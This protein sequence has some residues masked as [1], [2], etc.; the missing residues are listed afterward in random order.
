MSPAALPAPAVCTASKRS[1]V[2]Y[3][4][5]NQ[6]DEIN[7][8]Y[9][10]M[11]IDDPCIDKRCERQKDEPEERQKE[12]MIRALNVS[13]EQIQH[14]QNNPG[15][16]QGQD[17]QDARHVRPIMH[18]ARR[19]CPFETVPLGYNQ[20]GA[21]LLNPPNI[22]TLTRLALAPF[23]VP[24]ILAGRHSTALTL[25]VA[26][27]FTDVMDGGLARQFGWRTR[28]GEY[29]DPI[30]DKVLLSGIYVALAAVRTI[31]V[32]FVALIFGRDLLI[33]CSSGAALLLTR[34]RQFSPSVWG[35]ASTFFQIVTA[36]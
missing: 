15:K 19:F 30:A 33:L 31:P 14:Q 20:T 34:L 24:Y 10:E 35:K 17:E 2:D 7:V 36:V 6:H 18:A 21:M 25:F 27:A 26:A 11:V 4:R 5:H 13:C 32:W 28:A 3:G 16:R 22:L 9:R 23:V 1:D 29:L 8:G 12:V